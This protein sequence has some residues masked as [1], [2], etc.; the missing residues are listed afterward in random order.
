MR[1]LRELGYEQES[2]KT[3]PL[4]VLYSHVFVAPLRR[5]YSWAVPT[6]EA[7]ETIRSWSPD[8]VVEMGAGTGYWS[9]MLENQGIKVVPF[10]RNPT[11]L[12][13]INPQHHLVRETRLWDSKKAKNVPSF[14][15]VHIGGPDVLSSFPGHSLLLCWPT[16]EEE[17][18]VEDSVR[19]LAR[20][21]LEH[22]TGNTV[23]YVGEH[24]DP[25]STAGKQFLQ[26]LHEEWECRATIGIPQ[27]PGAKDS[28]TVW[29]RKV[30]LVCPYR[31]M[32]EEWQELQPLPYSMQEAEALRV[33][34]IETNQQRFENL[35]VGPIW[36]KKNRNASLK[37]VESDL[38][39]AWMIR[40][41]WFQRL[42]LK[43]GF[44]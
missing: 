37:K 30:P 20:D 43:Y 22:Y 12:H 2:C 31:S 16:A 18:G 14:L 6:S 19:F 35:V 34:W 4:S 32:A 41:S 28:L 24:G 23:I 38:L 44:K 40:S 39:D 10:D 29:T 25:A 21:C 9:W 36:R 1:L 7:L 42:G 26:K 33:A 11:H 15:P 27:W 8:G 5:M 17:V 3:S 13:R